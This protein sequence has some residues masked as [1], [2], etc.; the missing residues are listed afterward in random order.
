MSVLPMN[1]MSYP[2][3]QMNWISKRVALGMSMI[4]PANKKKMFLNQDER[5]VQDCFKKKK[6]KRKTIPADSC[7]KIATSK[8]M[9]DQKKKGR[10]AV[11]AKTQH[12]HHLERR[13]RGQKNLWFWKKFN[14]SECWIKFTLS[15][16]KGKYFTNRKK[17]KILSAM[18][19]NY[20]PNS[21]RDTSPSSEKKSPVYRHLYIETCVCVY[22]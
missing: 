21:L 15:L 2:I 9:R 5:E 7:Q 10:Q 17:D 12:C 20:F 3:L 22:I 19:G 4:S 8:D 6:K 18:K 11:C 1:Q 13:S 16:D 14:F